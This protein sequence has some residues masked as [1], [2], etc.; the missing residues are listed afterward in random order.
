MSK[1]QIKISYGV[2]KLFCIPIHY[3]KI[4]NFEEKKQDLINYAINMRDF[5]GRGRKASNRGGWQSQPFL[6]DG[7]DV[8]QKLLIDIISHIPSFKKNIDIRCDA[9]VNI[10]PPKSS[11]VKHCHPNSDIAGVLW[12][13]VPKKSG[14]I[15][16]VSPYDFLSFIEMHSYEDDFKKESN[17]YHEY[18]F[19][20]EEG[21]ILLFP[22]HLQHKVLENKSN[23]DRISVSFNLK[24]ENDN[25]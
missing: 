2:E 6:V 19:N 15:V 7:N 21:V 10:N 24:I 12:I 22:S 25:Y 23:E 4:D 13:K 8:L 5:G 9:W 11:N 17:Y 3:I 18:T 1:E 16:F 20:A 14:N